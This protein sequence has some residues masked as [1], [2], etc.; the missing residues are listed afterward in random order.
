MSQP[1]E[2]VK[3]H[4]TID[5]QQ[6]DPECDTGYS[7]AEWNALTHDERRTAYMNIWD[8]M[9]SADNGGIRVVTAGAE[10]V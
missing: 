9:A 10:E 2:T 7:V 3:L 4:I 5:I 8:A 6:D 1:D